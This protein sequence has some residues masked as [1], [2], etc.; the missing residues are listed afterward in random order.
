VTDAGNRSWNE[1][2]E[3]LRAVADQIR[4]AVDHKGPR[5]P[6][7]EAAA[8][9]LKADL[10]RLEQSAADLRT[11]LTTGV[12]EQRTEFE[13]SIDRERMTQSTDQLKASLDE[14]LGLAKT[15][16]IDLGSA[17][18]ATFEQVR[19]E[20][21]SA[22]RSLE[23]VAGSAGAWLRARLDSGGGTPRDRTPSGSPPLDDL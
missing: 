1:L 5:S 10:S 7:E 23:D 16:A 15:V 17:A 19:P 21:M 3:S 14:L 9:R 18:G 11:K 8:S 20:L 4:H 13:E 2:V 6:E 22:A 12:Q